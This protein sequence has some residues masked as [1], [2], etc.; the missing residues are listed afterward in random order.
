MSACSQEMDI[1]S[2]LRLA[3][4]SDSEV[5]THCFCGPNKYTHALGL[6]EFGGDMLFLCS[7]RC[8][9]NYTMTFLPPLSAYILL[10]MAIMYYFINKAPNNCQSRSKAIWTSSYNL[11][12][13]L[14][15]IP[16]MFLFFDINPVAENTNTKR[17]ATS[18]HIKIQHVPYSLTLTK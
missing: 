18:C 9:V 16:T 17:Y 2:T 1:T 14:S 11:F 3:R 4:Y 6:L 13:R 12:K 15:T 10:S 8:I 5:G 7:K